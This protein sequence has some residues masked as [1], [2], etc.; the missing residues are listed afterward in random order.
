[1]AIWKNYYLA[2]SPKDALEALADAPGDARVVAGGT[3]LLLELQQGLHRPVDTLVDITAIAEMNI[4]EM[5]PEGVFVGASVPLNNIV[6]SPL[7]A[8]HAHALLE[9]ASLIG[10]PQ[11]RNTATLGGNVAHA[12][13]AADGTI[14]LLALD[15]QAQIASA[16]GYRLA[17]VE[18][19]FQGP[20]RSTLDP[21][22]ELLVGFYLPRRSENSG[23]AFRRV[24]R[25]QGVAIAILNMSV[26]IQ[27]A[28][29][30][31]AAIRLAIGPGGPIPLRARAV[32]A[33]LRGREF[34]GDNLKR[35]LAELQEEVRF[36]TS[37]H[38][39]TREYRHQMAE[40]LFNETIA[41]AWQRASGES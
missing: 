20:G 35:G 36:R 30:L 22:K 25:P 13:P 16:A 39:A 37:P 27:R 41:T 11:V 40:V 1:M 2:Q 8:E 28:G 26:W 19:L 23:S 18:T 15:A 10:G 7:I 21:R 17:A 9:A 24:M 3:D 33:C 14:S 34:S 6:K 12:L 31:I 29:S 32:E 4:I 5:R 38:R